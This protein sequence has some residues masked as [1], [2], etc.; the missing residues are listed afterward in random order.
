MY[1]FNNATVITNFEG[2]TQEE[3][4]NKESNFFKNK[5]YELIERRWID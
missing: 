3:C 1:T 2:K 4:K 5:E